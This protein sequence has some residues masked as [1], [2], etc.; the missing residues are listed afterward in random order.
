[1]TGKV[2]QLTHPMCSVLIKQTNTA[3]RYLSVIHKSLE[4]AAS[5]P[6]QVF[7]GHS[8]PWYSNRDAA[9]R[10]TRVGPPKL[11]WTTTQNRPRTP[12]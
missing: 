8:C 12:Q 6:F 7:G 5:Q 1:M 9:A 4:Q 10:L 3:A 2:G 11:S